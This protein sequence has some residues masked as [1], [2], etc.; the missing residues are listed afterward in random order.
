MKRKQVWRYY[1][2]FCK[3]SGCSAYHIRMHGQGCTANP[4]RVCSFCKLIGNPQ[5]PIAE[6]IAI[7]IGKPENNYKL[8]LEA[9]TE[10]VE[11]CPACILSTIRQSGVQRAEKYSF[12]MNWEGTLIDPGCHI[13][14][15]FREAVTEFWKEHNSARAER[16]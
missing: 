13:E 7:L 12:D 10:F 14:F 11:G 3:K 1:C 5:H 16:Y 8:G 4:K 6:L 2:D 9:L 15:N